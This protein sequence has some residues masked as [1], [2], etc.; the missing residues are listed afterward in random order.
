M[1]EGNESVHSM[2]N[3]LF[4]KFRFFKSGISESECFISLLKPEILPFTDVGW[5]T[6]L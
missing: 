4:I 1:N 3:V 6:T 2:S 5:P